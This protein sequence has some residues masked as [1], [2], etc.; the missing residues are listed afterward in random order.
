MI[1]NYEIKKINNEEI[2][3]LFLDNNTEF[4]N[5]HP[6]KK[7][8]INNEINTY[9]KNNKINFNGKKI[10]LMAGSFMLGMC[11]LTT[12]P[13]KNKDIDYNKIQNIAS[14][15]KQKLNQ[16]RPETMAQAARISGVNPSDLSILAIYL[17]KEY[18][19]NE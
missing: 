12:P 17:K 18:S 19:K 15:A 3:F 5:M 6:E 16:I 9:I 11:L 1:N 13:H 14:E 2:L 10:I 4:A 8:T 7:K